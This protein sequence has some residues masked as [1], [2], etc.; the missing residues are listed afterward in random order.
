MS[1]D[2][3]PDRIWSV[4][5]VPEHTRRQVKMYAAARGINYGQALAEIAAPGE[6]TP[7][8]RAAFAML[9]RIASGG[10]RP[11]EGMPDKLWVVKGL[12]DDAYHAIKV[13]AALHDV[14]M[15]GALE[16]LVDSFIQQGAGDQYEAGTMPQHESRFDGNP[17]EL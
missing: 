1:Q 11:G 12:P 15:A 6:P 3:A 5:D 4:R 14:T 17:E 8:R 16:Q 13:H 2:Q 10:L 9:G 7:E